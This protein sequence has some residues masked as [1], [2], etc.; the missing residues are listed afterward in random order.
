LINQEF[1]ISQG[2]RGAV[3]AKLVEVRHAA[4]QPDREEFTVVFQSDSAANIEAGIYDVRQ[5]NAGRFQLYLEPATRPGSRG[6]F[7][8][9][10][11]LLS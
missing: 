10:F 7:T 11:N 2:R 6:A 5:G 8:A 4:T 9:S 3:G 1:R